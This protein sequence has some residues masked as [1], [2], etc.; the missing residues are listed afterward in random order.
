VVCQVLWFGMLC[1]W[2]ATLQRYEHGLRFA[3]LHK[4]VT[5]STMAMGG[6]N[7]SMAVLHTAAAPA[8]TR[9]PL[10]LG[11]IQGPL[12]VLKPN[13]SNQEGHA[14]ICHSFSMLGKHGML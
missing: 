10:L 6:V 5:Q 12:I 7:T 4:P 1:T 11:C 8:L 9:M 2:D 14:E 13:P 3:M